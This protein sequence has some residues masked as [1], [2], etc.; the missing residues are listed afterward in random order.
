MSLFINLF[1]IVFVVLS[2]IGTISYDKR[3]QLSELE[4]Q[5]LEQKALKGDID[6]SSKVNWHFVRGL[7]DRQKALN[8]IEQIANITDLE[9]TPLIILARY[10]LSIL[11]A[12]GEDFKIDKQKAR[13]YQRKAAEYIV[14]H[15]NKNCLNNNKKAFFYESKPSCDILANEITLQ[16]S[17]K[18]DIENTDNYLDY[19]KKYC[20]V[21]Q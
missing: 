6:A 17:F 1:F 8:H 4:F 7:G 20:S 16:Y 12:E 14:F 18:K 21:I 5:E 9:N 10:T 15:C 13:Y 19:Y 2:N 11:Y 3:E